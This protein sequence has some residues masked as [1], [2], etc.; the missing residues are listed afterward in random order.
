MY[1]TVHSLEGAQRVRGKDEDTEAAEV[2]RLGVAIK[3]D[4][5]PAANL[6]APMT[7]TAS[8]L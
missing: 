5:P 6:R 2:V 8:Q 4:R 1:S 7:I 3:V